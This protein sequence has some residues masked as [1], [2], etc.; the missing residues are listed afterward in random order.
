MTGD[1]FDHPEYIVGAVGDER[2][3]SSSRRYLTPHP[4]SSGRASVARRRI[5]AAEGSCP[6]GAVITRPSRAER[7]RAAR[8]GRPG[9]LSPNAAA[10][11]AGFRHPAMSGPNRR[12]G[13]VRPGRATPLHRGAAARRTRFRTLTADNRKDVV[14]MTSNFEIPPGRTC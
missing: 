11:E 9:E 10:I 3:C 1:L 5:L 12:S 7:R 13:R 6:C 2:G 14:C 4:N 8:E